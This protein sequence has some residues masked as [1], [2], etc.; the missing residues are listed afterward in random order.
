MVG[1]NTNTHLHLPLC[2]H[3]TICILYRLDNQRFCYFMILLIKY[4]P[5]PFQSFLSLSFILTLII[6]LTPNHTNVS[7][8]LISSPIPTGKNLRERREQFTSSTKKS[9]QQHNMHIHFMPKL[10]SPQI[11]ANQLPAQLAIICKRTSIWQL[12]R[13]LCFTYK[14][15][16][17][18]RMN[19][20]T[21]ISKS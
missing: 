12:I 3:Y 11:R 13:Q 19:I 10:Q 7:F 1:Q 17:K 15:R 6:T 14:S 16:L 5:Y 20:L 18:Q 2:L 8:F 9:K 4:L 21:P